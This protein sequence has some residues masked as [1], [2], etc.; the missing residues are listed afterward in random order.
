MLQHD[1]LSGLTD[2][3]CCTHQHTIETA[4]EILHTAGKAAAAEVQASQLKRFAVYFDVGRPLWQPKKAWMDMLAYDWDQLFKQGI[5]ADN[6]RPTSP[7]MPR[8]SSAAARMWIIAPIDGQLHYLR[9]GKNI[10]HGETE[11]IQEAD[12]QLQSIAF[13]LSSMNCCKMALT[14]FVRLQHI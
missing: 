14:T 10:R 8:P 2:Q 12:L 6:A 13:S 7:S 11:A 5:A 3:S 4:P 9:R 1:L